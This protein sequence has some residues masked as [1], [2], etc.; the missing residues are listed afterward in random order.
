MPDAWIL[1]RHKQSVLWRRASETTYRTGAAPLVESGPVPMPVRAVHWLDLESDTLVYAHKGALTVVRNLSS[2]PAASVVELPSR[3]Q[4]HALT[5]I[6]DV[7]FTGAADGP[8]MLGWVDLRAPLRWQGMVVPREVRVP[9]KGIDGFAAHGARLVAIDDIILPR[10]LLLLDVTDARAPRLVEAQDLPAHSSYE[11][12]V[13]VSSSG[14][15]LAML[16]TSANHGAFSAHVA[17]MDLPTLTEWAALHVQCEGS[18]RRWADR[19]YEL[20]AL[21]L[22][23][24][25]LFI[26]AGADG[27]G[28]L[29]VPPRPPDLAPRPRSAGYSNSRVPSI[30]VESLRL[31]PVPAGPV[32]D[33]APVDETS[34]FAVVEV[35]HGRLLKRSR[36]DAT[37]VSL[38]L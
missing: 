5:V 28:L 36:L 4:I 1:P 20:H 14:D 9:G 13:S 26:A 31:V 38:S 2:K 17:F 21:A 15:T 18:V 12:I 19:S 11:R 8:G 3:P 22:R 32:I 24:D 30:P 7:V 34:V 27:I 35:S 10:Y 25:M 6:D 23:G 16:S 37:L 29:R 33:V